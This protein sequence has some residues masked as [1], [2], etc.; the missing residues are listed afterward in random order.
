MMCS[1]QISKEQALEEL[2]K[3]LYPSAE[4][5]EQDLDYIPKKLGISGSEFNRI[6]LEPTHSHYE[7]AHDSHLKEL[8]SKLARLF[9]VTPKKTN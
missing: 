2:K 1:G 4:L 5:L 3:P 9:S 8:A 6:L 7:Y